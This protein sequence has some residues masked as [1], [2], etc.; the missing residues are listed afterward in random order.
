MCDWHELTVH[1]QSQMWGPCWP[2]IVQ[3]IITLLRVSASDLGTTLASGSS[4]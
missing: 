4:V 2:Y 3:V 1:V